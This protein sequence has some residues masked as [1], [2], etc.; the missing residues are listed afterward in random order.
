MWRKK[1]ASG[2]GENRGERKCKKSWRRVIFLCAQNLFVAKER[3]RKK[4]FSV[5]VV[6]LNFNFS[7][8]GKNRRNNLLPRAHKMLGRK[9]KTD[10]NSAL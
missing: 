2:T 6:Y 7:T 3:E 10:I 8:L 9:R 1:A 5:D 4:S